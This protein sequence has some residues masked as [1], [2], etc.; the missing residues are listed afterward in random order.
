M[1]RSVK[2]STLER[3]PIYFIMLSRY[4]VTLRIAL[5]I[6]FVM[7][8]FVN[9]GFSRL[10]SKRGRGNLDDGRGCGRGEQSHRSI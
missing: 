10:E 3:T 5:N 2:A 8:N 6:L 9:V 1:K 7:F 4:N